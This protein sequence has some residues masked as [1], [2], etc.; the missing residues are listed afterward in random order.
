MA[1][2]RLEEFKLEPW[3]GKHIQAITIS[4]AYDVL[5]EEQTKGFDTDPLVLVDRK[6]NRAFENVKPFGIIEIIER[7]DM[8]EVA[9]WIF[10]ELHRLSPVGDG[11]DPR[12]GHPGFY[13]NSHFIFVNETSVNADNVDSLNYD[14]SKD[15]LRFANVA[16]Y[17]RRIEGIFTSSRINPKTRKR[18]RK[19]KW[20]TFGWSPQAP[21]GVYRVVARKAKA[22]WGKNLD[23]R[24]TVRKIEGGARVRRWWKSGKKLSKFE[25]TDQVYPTIEIRPRAGGIII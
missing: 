9:E 25:M 6:P 2:R 7:A 21:K 4:A 17:S 11:D 12:Q 19:G 13:R 15:T 20:H 18:E 8:G 3:M 22:M 10:R 5:A 14:P 16:I 1:V 23:I 24:Y